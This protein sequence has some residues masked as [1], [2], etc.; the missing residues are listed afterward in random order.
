MPDGQAWPDAPTL[1]KQGFEQLQLNAS[2]RVSE[3]FDLVDPL[4]VRSHK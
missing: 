1:H 3:T 4:G 2:W